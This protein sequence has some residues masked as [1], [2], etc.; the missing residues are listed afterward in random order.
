MSGAGGC[1]CGAIRYRVD[2]PL[3]NVANC[4]CERCRRITGHFMAA[5]ACAQGD[6]AIDSEET[7]R[8]YRPVDEPGVAYGF[9]S[10]CGSSLFWRAET[11][12]G[13]IS[14]CAGTLDPPTGIV[15]DLALFGAEASDYHRLD[16]TIETADHDR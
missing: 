10:V 8:W 2:G 1:A 13:S 3:R 14:I 11:T 7:L 6:L 12:P 5:S 9:C 16:D 4:H 15:T